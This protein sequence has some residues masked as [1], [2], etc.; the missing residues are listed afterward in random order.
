MAVVMSDLPEGYRWATAEEC[1]TYA[2]ATSS[3]PGAIVVK[4]TVDSSGH[5]YT[6]DESDLAVPIEKCSHC[7]TPL[8]NED[9]P[10]YGYGE[11][12]A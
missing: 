8:V 2:K 10:N 11:Y 7:G 1:E 4:R 6:Q 5:V 9:C 3:V 12:H